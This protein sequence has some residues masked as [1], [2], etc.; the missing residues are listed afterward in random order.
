MQLGSGGDIV[1]IPTASPGKTHVG[2]PGKLDFYFLFIR[3]LR[4]I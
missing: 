2:E 1:S 4:K 3:F